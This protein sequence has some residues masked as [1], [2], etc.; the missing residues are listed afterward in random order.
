M[1]VV[2]ED[3]EEFCMVSHVGNGMTHSIAHPSNFC[4]SLCQVD[5]QISHKNS[6]SKAGLRLYTYSRVYMTVS[7][8]TTMSW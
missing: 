7:F 5:F 2:T 4:M 3:V 8:V 1:H 6:L